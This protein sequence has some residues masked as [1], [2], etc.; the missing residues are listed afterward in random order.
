MAAARAAASDRAVMKVFEDQGQLTVEIP[1]IRRWKSIARDCCMLALWTAMACGLTRLAP[2]PQFP[3]QYAIS[4]AARVTLGILCL[5]GILRLV[6]RLW[7]REEIVL[8]GGLLTVVWR[9]GLL[10]WQRAY[11]VGEVRDLHVSGI[12]LPQQLRV[13]G[14]TLQFHYRGKTG[15]FADRLERAEAQALLTHF[16]GRMPQSNWTPVLGL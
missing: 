2:P 8:R 10:G 7:G 12:G 4:V 6:W 16:R 14:G 9:L 3:T 15:R 1:P 11:R 13:V 5:S